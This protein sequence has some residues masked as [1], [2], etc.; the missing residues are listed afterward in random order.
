MNGIDNVSNWKKNRA[1]NKNE[2]KP[3]SYLLLRAICEMNVSNQLKSI[4]YLVSKLYCGLLINNNFGKKFMNTFL[5]HGAMRCVCGERKCTL[6]TTTV[7]QMLQ[8]HKYIRMND[9]N[10][11]QWRRPIFRCKATHAANEMRANYKQ[12][13]GDEHK[14]RGRWKTKKQKWSVWKFTIKYRCDFC[15]F[16]A[17][18]LVF[19]AS[20][21]WLVSLFFLLIS[22]A[23]KKHT[24]TENRP[25]CDIVLLWKISGE[26]W[27]FNSDQ[28]N[29]NKNNRPKKTML[30]KYPKQYSEFSS[31]IIKNYL[32]GRWKSVRFPCL[33]LLF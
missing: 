21:C 31:F 20:Y 17:N 11:R 26:I 2:T 3:T 16:Y 32:M 19:L 28:S 22:L 25:C 12:T 5:T 14:Y 30:N 9:S 29:R 27:R 18:C 15:W 6:S 24:H 4:I 23:I 8:H 33:S 13:A 10:D 7:T 1:K